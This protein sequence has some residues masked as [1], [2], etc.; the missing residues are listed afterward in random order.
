M[1]ATMPMYDWPE[2][3]AENDNQWAK[4]RDALRAEGLDAP[5]KLNREI[6]YTDSWTRPDLV[7]GQACGLPFVKELLGKV[8]LIGAVKM[9]LEG[10]APGQYNSHIIV[11]QNSDL[12][13]DDLA[14]RKYAYNTACSQSGLA[15]LV[16]MGLT[17]GDALESGGHRASIKMIAEGHADFAAIDAQSW[18]LARDFEPSAGGVRIIGQT[19]P[20]PAPVWIAAKGAD[21]ETYRSALDVVK[22]SDDEYLSLL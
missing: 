19:K 3:W 12:T 6:G 7:L 4:M 21:V 11:H 5:E 10:C 18:K 16:K 13:M 8:S 17:G 9:D 22:V 1:L 20:T 15:C 2:V 14:G